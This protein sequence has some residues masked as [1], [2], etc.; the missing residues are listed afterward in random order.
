[1]SDPIPLISN[2][3]ILW[4]QICDFIPYI[5]HVF[6]VLCLNQGGIG[7]YQQRE[8]MLNPHF[9]QLINQGSRLNRRSWLSKSQLAKQVTSRT[10]SRENP[11]RLQHLGDPRA[12][13]RPMLL[14]EPKKDLSKSPGIKGMISKLLESFHSPWLWRFG[15]KKCWVMV[16]EPLNE[17]S[18]A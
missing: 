1:M 13:A 11:Q 8:I 6:W 4:S 3:L 18:M 7:L 16:V 5:Q 12:E 2:T 9:Q 14:G 17:L 10:L 15:P